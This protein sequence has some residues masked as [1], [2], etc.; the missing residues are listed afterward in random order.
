MT[1]ACDICTSPIN[2][3]GGICHRCRLAYCLEVDSTASRRCAADKGHG[4]DHYTTDDR[5]EI[6]HRW[7][8]GGVAREVG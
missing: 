5:G 6:T 2:Q 3:H 8:A 4:G 1:L 7:G